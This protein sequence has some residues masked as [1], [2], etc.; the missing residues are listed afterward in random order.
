MNKIAQSDTVGQTCHPNGS[1]DVMSTPDRVLL[2]L[3]TEKLTATFDRDIKVVGN[4]H[5]GFEMSA[6]F[7]TAKWFSE[8]AGRSQL[9]LGKINYDLPTLLADLQERINNGDPNREFSL[10]DYQAGVL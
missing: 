5:A 9:W 4:K 10:D 1:I 8:G 7:T 2:R 6:S 3:D